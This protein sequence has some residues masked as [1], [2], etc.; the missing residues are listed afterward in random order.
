MDTNRIEIKVLEAPSIAKRRGEVAVVMGVIEVGTIF[1]RFTIPHRDSRRG[2]GY[3]RPV[4]MV[5]VRRLAS[6]L[7]AENADLPT[8]V[9]LN[10][11]D[12]NENTDLIHRDGSVFL[13]TAADFYVVDGQHRIEALAYLYEEDPKKWAGYPLSFV[14]M[15]GA[16]EDEEMN[17]FY[18]VNST[19]KSVKTDLAFDLLAQQG[20]NPDVLADHEA[21]GT[22]WKIRTQNL[23]RRLSDE[24]PTW[25][26]RVRFP[27]EPKAETT[28]S[29]SGLATSLRPVLE[30]KFFDI[31]SEEN[32]VQIINAYW[33]GIAR[34]LPA[35]FVRG[36]EEEYGIQKQTGAVVLHKVFATVLEIIREQR[37]PTNDPKSYEQVMRTPLEIL[38]GT[39]NEGDTV[40]GSDFWIAGSQGAAGAFTSGA[41]Q[42]ALVAVL[43]RNLK[44][45]HVRV[46]QGK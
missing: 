7:K 42:R 38:E 3:Q 46:T 28:I 36:G 11:R 37:L 41:G 18:V 30:H 17:Q 21:K 44:E 25:Q 23:T 15:L 10:I 31:Q 22:D 32:K 13:Q 8:T 4:Q 9:L 40:S 12:Y 20:L 33:E 14:C 6:E 43:N 26:G 19:A 27:G 16:D 45:E 2:V 1:G 34:V 24:A 39:N 29:N 35:A 5:R